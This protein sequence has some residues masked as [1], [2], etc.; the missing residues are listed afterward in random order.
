LIDAFEGRENKT[1]ARA[2]ITSI[3]IV[4]KLIVIAVP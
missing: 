4:L 3:F 2:Q 1:A